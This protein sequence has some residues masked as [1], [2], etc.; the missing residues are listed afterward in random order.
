MLLLCG[1]LTVPTLGL[2]GSVAEADRQAGFA[3]EELREG[4]YERALHSAESALRL[5]PTSYETL[6]LKALAYEGLHQLRL[7]ESLLL[8][9]QEVGGL[10][11]LPSP[12]DAALLRLR[13]DLRG[14]QQLRAKRNRGR[15]VALV[16]EPMA[17][18][19]QVVA[20]E[21]EV[22]RERSQAALQS[23]QC[24][25]AMVA[26]LE[27]IG[28]DPSEAVGY[29]LLGD[30]E[31]CQGR[32]RRAALAYRRYQAR[33][34]N[35]GS[36]SD[37][38]SDLLL[39]LATLEVEAS[40]QDGAVVPLLQIEI[41]DQRIDPI[42]RDRTSAR[43]EDLPF[44]QP[45]V[46]VVA[47]RGLRA[48]SIT[49]DPLRPTEV[50]TVTV[51]PEVVGLGTV[52]LAGFDA[53]MALV[54]IRTPDEEAVAR[55]AQQ[56]E[57]TAGE[58]I[59]TTSTEL[60]SVDVSLT[61][62]PGEEVAFDPSRHLPAGLAVT[63]VPAGSELRIVV[64][65]RSGVVV[66]R[67]ERVP[68]EFGTLDPKYGLRLAPELTF[69][70]L[71]GG[72]GGV[73]LSHPR[74]GEVAQE[75]V[76][77]NGAWSGTRFDVSEMQGTA[78][79]TARWQAW[80]R[81]KEGAIVRHRRAA[82]VTAV[83]AGVLAGGAAAAWGLSQVAA[84]RRVRPSLICGALGA[85]AESCAEAARLKSQQDGL[86]GGGVVIVG[87]GVASVALSVSFGVRARR[88]AIDTSGWDPW[89]AGHDG[90]EEG[91]R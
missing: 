55:P 44:G 21:P 83:L 8:A 14:E 50:R 33:G 67:V 6:G 91:V 62:A 18:T 38:L 16:A 35:D 28:A 77:E 4:N 36:V 63:G 52:V 32:P 19:T 17:P 7:A 46:L 23:G 89:P 86:V 34:G 72:P 65:G 90:G 74:L 71:L 59:V 66:E 13:A 15:V 31:R 47:G 75:I 24:N 10:A 56:K 25:A 60:G 81:A 53:E 20:A 5:D 57:V 1:T 26:A 87:L 48:E 43:F 82:A 54:T 22:Y 27:L 70:S 58:V 40:T 3:R 85:S 37:L 69:D 2:A 84:N 73:W 12:Y 9:W 68:P 51:A 80:R 61:V 64:E 45:L 49:L 76:L 88:N 29:R 42:R 41:D 39:S 11:E 30:A 78:E 79:A